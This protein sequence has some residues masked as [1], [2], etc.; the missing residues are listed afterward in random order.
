MFSEAML[1]IRTKKAR[2]NLARLFGG[3]KR[4]ARELPTKTNNAELSSEQRVAEI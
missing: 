2:R 3:E 1:L 4:T